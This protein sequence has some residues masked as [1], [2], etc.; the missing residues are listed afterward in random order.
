MVGR[1]GLSSRGEGLQQTGN[2]F[3]RCA[4]GMSCWYGQV[5]VRTERLSRDGRW[6]RTRRICA[7]KLSDGIVRRICATKFPRTLG[8]R[9]VSSV[10]IRGFRSWPLHQ[11]RQRLEEGATVSWCLGGQQLWELGNAHPRAFRATKSRFPMRFS[12]VLGG[13]MTC[14]QLSSVFWMTPTDSSH[15]KSHVV[16]AVPMLSTIPC[17]TIRK[18]EDRCVPKFLGP[19]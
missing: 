7:T 9:L 11:S 13:V 5:S 12:T 15:P 4:P 19:T 16:V 10:L 14:R 17:E 1:G 2:H 3:P 18:R 8:A 6:W